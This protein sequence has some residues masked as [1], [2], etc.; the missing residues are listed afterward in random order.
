[1]AEFQQCAG[2]PTNPPC[3][4]C[5]NAPRAMRQGRPA[6]IVQKLSRKDRP[7]LDRS[8]M[9]FGNHEW[10][11]IDPAVQP[12]DFAHPD[13]APRRDFNNAFNRPH[14]ETNVNIDVI[15]R[16]GTEIETDGVGIEGVWF[17]VR[18]PSFKDGVVTAHL[19]RKEGGE[20]VLVSAVDLGVVAE[21]FSNLYNDKV[22]TKLVSGGKANK[23]SRAALTK[24]TD[25]TYK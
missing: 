11:Y 7:P 18:V 13:G 24:Q 4:N 20:V 5:P 3:A 1:M 21:R 9:G 19:T 12:T 16:P 25:E 6:P 14:E 22:I 17:V 10:E 23:A 2:C 15:S 8:K